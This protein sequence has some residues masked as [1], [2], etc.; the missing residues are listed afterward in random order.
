MRDQRYAPRSEQDLLKLVTEHPLAWI[1]SGVGPDFRARLLP[2][3]PLKTEGGRLTQLAGHFPRYDDQIDLLKNDPQAQLLFLGPHDYISA[4]WVSD[5]SWSPTW[6]FVS[7]RCSVNI[8]FFEDPEQLRHTLDDLVTTMEAG[9]EQAW[10]I[11]DMGPRY[12]SL[13]KHIIG[14]VAHIQESEE[15]YKLGQDEHETAYQEV[16]SA[17]QREG[18][19][20]LIDWMKRFNPGR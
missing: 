18:R 8:E 10:S 6:N 15:R 17:L 14:F 19:D 13:S 7:A 1:V 20:D 2:L 12:D 3:R 5:K 9:R 4:S 11:E 16:L